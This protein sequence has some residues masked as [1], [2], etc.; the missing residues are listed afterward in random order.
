[1][2]DMPGVGVAGESEMEVGRQ[3]F[4]SERARGMLQAQDRVVLI[5]DAS[6][7]S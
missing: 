3:C 6:A 5:E 1:M 2:D 7:I 4:G